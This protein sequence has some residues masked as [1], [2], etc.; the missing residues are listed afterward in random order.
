MKGGG[1]KKMKMSCG[2]GDIVEEAESA[3]DWKHDRGLAAVGR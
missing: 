1:L 3:W 2:L